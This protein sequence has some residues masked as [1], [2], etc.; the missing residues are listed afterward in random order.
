MG[1]GLTSDPDPARLAD[2]LTLAER[3]LQALYCSVERRQLYDATAWLAVLDG[4]E[5]TVPDV[6]A[7]DPD[8]AA[9]LRD[10][11]GWLAVGDGGQPLQ[12]DWVEGMIRLAGVLGELRALA[13][14]YTPWSAD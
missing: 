8:L 2:A 10:A 11:L 5:G 4:I 9:Q 1:R 12:A 6:E 7:I 3:R 13:L 14:P